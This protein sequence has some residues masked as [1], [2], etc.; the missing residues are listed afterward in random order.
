[1]FFK[2]RRIENQAYKDFNW[3]D[4]NAKTNGEKYFL[5]RYAG[6]WKLCLDIG[7]NEGNYAEMVL[8]INPKCRVICFEPNPDLINKIKVKNITEVH[9]LAVSSNSGFVNININM[10]DPT[11]SSIYRKNDDTKSVCVP[12]VTIDE[13]AEKH[14]L[15]TID[16]IKIDT[17]GNEVSVLKGMRNLCANR[18]VDMIQFEYGGTYLDAKTTLLEVYELMSKNY[19]I[20]HLMPSGVIPLRYSSELEKFRYSNWIAVSRDIYAKS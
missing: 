6:T 18:A 7:A 5:E 3:D 19:I 17:E 12:S 15:H 2:K 8:K 16:F 1:M 11:Q 4:C 9:N 20:C 13:F 14:N 10:A